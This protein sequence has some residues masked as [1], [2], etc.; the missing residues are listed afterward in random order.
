[1]NFEGYEARLPTAEDV[2]IQKLRWS[3]GGKR[4]KDISDATEVI[5]LQRSKLDLPYIRHWTDQ[6]LTTELFDKLLAKAELP[7]QWILE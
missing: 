2:I 3:R 7:Q 5:R 1:M 6:H 4:A